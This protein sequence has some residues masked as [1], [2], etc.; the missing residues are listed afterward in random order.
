M[1]KEHFPLEEM[2]DY[3][4]ASSCAIELDRFK[5]DLPIAD[6]RVIPYF[7]NILLNTAQKLR[8]N[9][10]LEPPFR[11]VHISFPMDFNLFRTVKIAYDD[12]YPSLVSQAYPLAAQKL[13]QTSRTIRNYRKL[14]DNDLEL[15]IN[16]MIN[17]SR[18]IRVMNQADYK[19]YL[20][21]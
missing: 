12:E 10:P 17:L 11:V 1:P 9:K 16:Q 18:A 3:W 5:R 13:E 15:S 7:S 19:R 2:E 20:A 6:R 14:S 8:G 4:L 21:A